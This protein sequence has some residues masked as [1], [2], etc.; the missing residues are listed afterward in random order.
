[1][2]PY[3][4]VEA[5]PE[6]IVLLNP[7]LKPYDFDR[8]G[9]ELLILGTFGKGVFKQVYSPAR[10]A[11]GW[12]CVARVDNYDIYKRRDLAAKPLEVTPA[13]SPK[14]VKLASRRG[15]NAPKPPANPHHH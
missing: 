5:T 3:F 6:R 15:A 11:Q 2:P 7:Q 4:F 8:V 14:R 13:P 12:R 1:M 9:A 10:L